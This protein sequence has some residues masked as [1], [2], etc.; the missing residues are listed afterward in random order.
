MKSANCGEVNYATLAAAYRN[1]FL[2]FI[3]Q[4]INIRTYQG[5]YLRGWFREDGL[6][7]ATELQFQHCF[8]NSDRRFQG[9]DSFR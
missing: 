6:Q 4:S 7:F 2:D 9:Q 1:L 5:L 3:F 8:V